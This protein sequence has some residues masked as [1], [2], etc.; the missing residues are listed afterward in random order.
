MDVC[1]SVRF[2]DGLFSSR[3]DCAHGAAASWRQIDRCRSAVLHPTQR[4]SGANTF[5]S[6]DVSALLVPNRSFDIRSLYFVVC[7]IE[8][9]SLVFQ[10][11]SNV[12]TSLF[13]VRL[14]D[15]P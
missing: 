2:I 10:I 14:Q 9:Q 12:H 8:R 11:H 7:T 3:I 13:C 5:N 15:E 1:F 6:V 4:W